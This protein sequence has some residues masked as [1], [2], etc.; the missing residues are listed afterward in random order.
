MNAEYSEPRNLTVASKLQRSAQMT[1]VR[2]SPH[3][4][5]SHTVHD[6]TSPTWSQSSLLRSN[7]ITFSEE[8]PSSFTYARYII[9]EQ[10][11]VRLAH[12]LI[13]RPGF[14]EGLF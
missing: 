6:S 3:T 9:T 1:M 4:N 5:T 10:A 8:S 11:D 7:R 14:R 12:H 13:L 2:S